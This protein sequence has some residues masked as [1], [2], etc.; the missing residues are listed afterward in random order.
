MARAVMSQ[1]VRYGEVRRGRLG[2][3]MG[4]LTPALAKKL[5]VAAQEGAIIARVQPGSPAETAGLRERDVVVA[6]N[7]RPIRSSAELH[8][9]L[10]LTP[11]GEEVELRVIRGKSTRTVRARVAAPQELTSAVG[12]S[13]PQLAGLKVVEIEPGSPLYERIQGLIVASVEAESRAWNAG[14]RQGDIIYAVNRR[15]VRNLEEFQAALRGS[16][17]GF[18]VSLVRGDFNLTIIVR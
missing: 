15:R 13:V 7:G 3:G 14:F 5:G 8:A 17:R 12:Q 6:V 11:V 10:G 1:I 4:D 18:T 16:E 2:I 9:R